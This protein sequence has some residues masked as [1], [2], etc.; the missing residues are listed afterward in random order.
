MN[1]NKRSDEIINF[2]FNLDISKNTYCFTSLEYQNPINFKGDNIPDKDSIALLSSVNIN[3][4]DEEGFSRDL[5][6][7]IDETGS[8]KAEDKSYLN[9]ETLKTFYFQFLIHVISRFKH[10]NGELTTSN[11]N[12]EF[13]DTNKIKYLKAYREE[14][15]SFYKG[16]SLG[17][18]N[19]GLS[20]RDSQL[21]FYIKIG[22]KNLILIKKKVF[23]KF[24][25]TFVLKC[26]ETIIRFILKKL[27]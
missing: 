27:G 19:I 22:I 15:K 4:T 16:G 3:F 12:I 20:G 1:K 14:A 11:F 8:Y 23:Q 24:F 7:K 13:F 26:S 21:R 17:S 6:F 25:K 9:E 18:E 10:L 5:T 2:L